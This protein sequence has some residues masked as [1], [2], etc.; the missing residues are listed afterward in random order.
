LLPNK[1]SPCAKAKGFFFALGALAVHLT[2]MPRAAPRS[3]NATHD[4]AIPSPHPLEG[5]VKGLFFSLREKV[6]MR[7]INKINAF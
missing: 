1:S 2:A 7:E 4:M 3:M 6:R 5:V